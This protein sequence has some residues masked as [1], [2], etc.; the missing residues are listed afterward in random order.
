MVFYYNIHN[1]HG[2]RKVKLLTAFTISP[3]PV[4]RFS[5]VKSPLFLLLPVR[6]TTGAQTSKTALCVC[7][8]GHT[9]LWAFLCSSQLTHMNRKIHKLKPK[10]CRCSTVLA[11]FASAQVEAICS[12]KGKYKLQTVCCVHGKRNHT[13]W[14]RFSSTVLYLA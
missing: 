7:A 5:D 6:G 11:H 14:T 1:S 9:D 3:L 10:D 13:A 12:G 2:G 4:T 8:T